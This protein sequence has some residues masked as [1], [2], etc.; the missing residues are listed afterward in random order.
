MSPKKGTNF[1]WVPAFSPEPPQFSGVLHLVL[2]DSF[3]RHPIRFKGNSETANENQ[4][5]SGYYSNHV[6]QK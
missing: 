1:L 5:I 3:L 4:A 2:R 6:E